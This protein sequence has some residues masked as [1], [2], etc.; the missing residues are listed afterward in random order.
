VK[1]AV[2][3][4]YVAMRQGAMT[5]G[6]EGVWFTAELGRTT[7][8]S[9]GLRSTMTSSGPDWR[10]VEWPAQYFQDEGLEAGKQDA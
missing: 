5:A 3:S 2:L 8:M 9:Y 6:N 4:W 1:G 10:A 7:V